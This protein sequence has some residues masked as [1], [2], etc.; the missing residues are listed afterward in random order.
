MITTLTINSENGLP[1]PYVMFHSIPPDRPDGQHLNSMTGASN[2]VA[3]A[4]YTG[5]TSVSR[6]AHKHK[7]TCSR[8]IADCDRLAT[9]C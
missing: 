6:P 7:L 9:S 5:D 1:C 3:R 2:R 4:S 8:S